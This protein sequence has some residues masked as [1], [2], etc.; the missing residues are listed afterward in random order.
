MLHASPKEI[1]ESRT[2]DFQVMDAGI[3]QAELLC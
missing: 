2:I 3:L 1:P